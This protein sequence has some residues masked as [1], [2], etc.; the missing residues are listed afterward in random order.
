[1][2]PNH[3]KDVRGGN[4][5]SNEI[6]KVVFGAPVMPSPILRE[7]LDRRRL[8]RL[9]FVSDLGKLPAW[10]VDALIY[11]DSKF[12]ELLEKKAKQNGRK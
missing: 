12:D 2:W 4:A 10:K 5:L 3:G 8:K 9:G 7:Y 1:V 11:I 6:F